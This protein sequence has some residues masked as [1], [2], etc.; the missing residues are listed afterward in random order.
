MTDLPTRVNK[1]VADF[2]AKRPAMARLVFALD[3]TASRQPTWDQACHLQGQ[4]FTEAGKVGALQI[5]LVYFRGL[6]E[7][8]QS[9]WTNSAQELAREMTRISCEAGYT[10]IGKILAHIRKENTAQKIN[11][12]CFVGDA[13]EEIPGDLYDAARGLGV[14][15]F[16]F[17]E[18]ADP[19]VETTFREMARLSTDGAFNGAYS[20]FESGA[21][22]KL[23]NLLRAVAA[24]ATGGLTAL[25]DQRTDA[26]RKLLGQ[27]KKE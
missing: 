9:R 14:P 2:L 21:E 17:Q 23:A 6:N 24:F 16:M 1:Q 11:A 10:Q 25:A 4:M 15:L 19:V 13:M 22:A 12:A 7:C 26:A 18:G 27:M 20:R 3:A 5:Q 8:R